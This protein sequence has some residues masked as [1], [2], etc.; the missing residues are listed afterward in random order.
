[1][2]IAFILVPV[3]LDIVLVFFFAGPLLFPL[4]ALL[5][6][7][8]RCLVHILHSQFHFHAFNLDGYTHDLSHLLLSQLLFMHLEFMQPVVVG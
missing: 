5:L 6:P 8:F 3:L 4:S 1:M 7:A 2:S